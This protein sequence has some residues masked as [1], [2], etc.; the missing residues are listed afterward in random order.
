M[1]IE[2]SIVLLA[3]LDALMETV[4]SYSTEPEILGTLTGA[5]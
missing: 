1:V 3:N 4:S 2:C 5:V